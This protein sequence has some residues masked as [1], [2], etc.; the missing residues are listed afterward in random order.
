MK[1]FDKDVLGCHIEKLTSGAGGCSDYTV[2]GIVNKLSDSLKILAEGCKN[3]SSDGRFDQACTACLRGWED[4]GGP[5]DDDLNN[6]KAT[7]D[8]CRFAVLVTLVGI[9][10]DNAKWIQAVF[11]CLEEQPLAL[12]SDESLSKESSCLK[13]A[14]KEVY[15]A[16]NNL[17][18]SN[19]IGQG[20]AGKVYKGILSNGQQVAVKHIISDG[21]V[22]TFVREVR[23]LSHV[24]HPNLV[25]LLSYCEDHNECFLVYE[26]CHNGNLSEW[27]YGKAGVLSWIQRLKIAIDSATGLWFLH[28]YPEGCIIHRDIKP[29][30]ILINADFQAKLSDFGLSKVM[31]IGQSYVSSEVRGTFGYV[32]PEY[33]RNHHV[34]T[35]GDVYSFGVV[36]LQLLS[37]QRVINLGDNRPMPLDKMAKFVMRGGNI[38]KFAD[39]KINGEYSVEA[40]DLVFKLALSCTGLKQQRPSMEQVV[41]RLEKALDISKTSNSY[42]SHHNCIDGSR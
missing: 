29:T 7:A 41:L 37:G 13:I 18:A 31:D 26:L 32:D 5:S 2:E 12:A 22:D 21:Y 20:V 36:L 6:G 42:R 3:L 38:A 9:W 17:S 4:I 30:N 8:V 15:S 23:S 25:A 28:T 11:K 1:E 16:T 27:L 35:S 14:I 10:V 34:S 24:Q 39:P 40:F 19:Y 33:R